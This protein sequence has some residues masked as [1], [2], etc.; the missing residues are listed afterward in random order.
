MDIVEAGDG[1]FATRRF[2]AGEHILDYRYI[3]GVS[4]NGDEVDWLSA[5]TFSERYAPSDGVPLG[6]AKYVLHPQGSPYYYDTARTGGVGGKANTR[7]G[8]QTARFKGSQLHAGQRA[9]QP[10]DEIFV[11]YGSG[12]RFGNDID[13]ERQGWTFAR[14]RPIPH[15]NRTRATPAPPPPGG[16]RGGK[17]F[18][19][20]LGV[21]APT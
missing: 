14:R 19:H 21:S 9:V 13:D 16:G 5:D 8:G 10:G 11:P 18:Q 2:K 6:N 17:P 4:R 3:H 20:S 12:Y 1:L 7:R 15:F